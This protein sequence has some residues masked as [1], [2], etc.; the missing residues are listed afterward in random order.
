[1]LDVLFSE[2]NCQLQSDEGQQSLNAFG[3]LAIFLHKNYLK[4]TGCK[5]SAKSNMLQC[6]IDDK[7][8]FLYD[9][10]FMKRPWVDVGLPC[11]F[12]RYMPL[13]KLAV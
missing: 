12:R 5:R 11:A 4:S 2:D 13:S 7:V 9:Q 3:K 1:M 8:I 6:L 10:K